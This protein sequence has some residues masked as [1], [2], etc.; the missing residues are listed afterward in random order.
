MS[1]ASS[2]GSLLSARV[3]S[4]ARDAPA[5]NLQIISLPADLES[6]PLPERLR[7]EVVRVLQSNE[8]TIRTERGDIRVQI[9]DG[10]RVNIE[11]GS[12]IEIRLDAGAPRE[13]GY[14]RPDPSQ[15]VSDV[16]ANRADAEPQRNI[17]VPPP[18]DI[19]RLVQSAT[20]YTVTRL[21]DTVSRDVDI[22]RPYIPTT[23]HVLTP[24]SQYQ[25][26]VVADSGALA[27][28]VIAPSSSVVDDF[29]SLTPAVETNV[30]AQVSQAVL[31]APVLE[32]PL[33]VIAAQTLT[34]PP[35]QL[36]TTALGALN[37]PPAQQASIAQA[38]I[39]DVSAPIPTLI[40]NATLS[41]A[42]QFAAVDAALAGEVRGIL[43]GFSPEQHFPILEITTPG[44]FAHQLYLLDVP[45][46]DVAVG[47]ELTLN[48]TQI[49]NTPV[50]VLPVQAAFPPI[51]SAYF[52]SAENWPV[53]QDALAT[54]TA[55]TTQ[56]SAQMVL[57]SPSAPAN[58][59]PAALFF[60]A[61]MRS[62]DIHG[63]LGERAVEVLRSSGKGNLIERIGREMLGLAR[64]NAEPVSQDWR[65]LSLPLAWQDEVHKMVVYY[66]R[67]G[68][69]SNSQDEDRGENTRFVMDLSLSNM[70]KVQLDALFGKRENDARLDLILRTE[71]S[72]SAAMKQQMRESYKRALDET[73]ISGEL[74]FQGDI[75][76]WVRITP[77]VISEYSRDI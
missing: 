57:P 37:V 66:R 68:Q 13:T 24:V 7:G 18:Q 59:T 40:S 54:L 8:I 42:E 48:I 62:G 34:T 58:I 15:R 72:F 30:T 9:Q 26:P 45:L 32:V 76:H 43:I 2:I 36:V 23:Y 47:R 21:P 38:F 12:T 35:E 77:D 44:R 49:Q 51:T 52:L 67:E 19:E 1:D 16:G 17:N 73:K 63:W 53:F 11:D 10:A 69:Q 5:P 39:D 75:E 22:V 70:G 50:N 74:S 25:A 28:V 64:L 27:F 3:E 14:I 29:L 61:A 56:I 46:Q 71:N 33:P 6:G 20:A 55:S 65:A 31:S 60:I 41:S 4:N